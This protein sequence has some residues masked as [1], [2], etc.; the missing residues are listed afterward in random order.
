M[1]GRQAGVQFGHGPF[2]YGF[3]CI[4]RA[5]FRHVDDDSKGNKFVA[6]AYFFVRVHDNPG[7]Y[8]GLVNLSML[9]LLELKSMNPQTVIAMLVV[10][11][12]AVFVLRSWFSF[13]VGLFR[14][15]DPTKNSQSSCGGCVNGCQK[16]SN[17]PRLVELK[18]EGP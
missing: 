3:L 4:V 2:D 13:W 11:M 1:A 9:P 6:L 16:A 7:I 14:K 18:R 17:G 15:P 8:W 5:V 12:C 10:A